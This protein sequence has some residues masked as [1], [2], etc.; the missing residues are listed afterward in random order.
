MDNGGCTGHFKIDGKSFSRIP[1]DEDGRCPDCA[2]KNGE[3]HHWHCDQE[4]CPKCKGQA[5]CCECESFE[6]I[7]VKQKLTFTQQKAQNIIDT[8]S[9]QMID[10]NTYRVK[11]YVIGPSMQCPCKGFLDRNDCSHI[12][13]VKMMQQQVKKE[14]MIA[15]VKKYS[16]EE[17]IQRHRLLYSNLRQKEWSNE[18]EYEKWS[19]QVISWSEEMAILESMME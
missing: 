15:K 5:L 9:I 18:E 8:K 11:S 12:Q 3:I 17:K 2:V 14:T 7:V 4:R 1:Y 19:S 16:N 13:A 6:L 10:G